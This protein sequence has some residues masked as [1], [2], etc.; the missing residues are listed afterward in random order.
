LGAPINALGRISAYIKGDVAKQV[1]TLFISGKRVSIDDLKENTES[2]D[3]YDRSITSLLRM[4]LVDERIQV[5]GSAVRA[6]STGR[7]IAV[8]DLIQAMEECTSLTA[9]KRIENLKTGGHITEGA[10]S[11]FKKFRYGNQW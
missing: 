11:E 6:D 3:D 5:L 7:L 10:T 2:S 4:D 9:Q 8:K 1:H